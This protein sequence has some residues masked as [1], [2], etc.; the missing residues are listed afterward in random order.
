MIPNSLFP[1]HGSRSL[2][3]G[4]QHH[5]GLATSFA[6]NANWRATHGKT[7]RE[8]AA[9]VGLRRDWLKVCGLARDLQPGLGPTK[10]AIARAKP[11]NAAIPAGSS[12]QSRSISTVA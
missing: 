2:V 3:R 5:V 6:L 4:A 12:R 11:R 10:I 8:S 1:S 9:S 7:G